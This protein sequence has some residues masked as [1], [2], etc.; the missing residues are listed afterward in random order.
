M[1]PSSDNNGKSISPNVINIDI[2]PNGTPNASTV[3]K[4]KL[5]DLAESIITKDYGPTPFQSLRPSFSQQYQEPISSSEQWKQNKR[6]QQKEDILSKISM[7]SETVAISDDRQVI[8]IT[9]SPSPRQRNVF[10]E[11]VSPT[12][13]QIF[14]H[15]KR[16]LPAPV[17]QEFTLDCYVK[18]RIAEA[19]RTEGDKRSDEGELKGSHHSEHNIKTNLQEQSMMNVM[20]QTITIGGKDEPTSSANASITPFYPY[21]ALNMVASGAQILSPNVLSES[22]LESDN[23]ANVQSKSTISQISLQGS[24]LAEPK[25]LLSAQYEA[26]SDED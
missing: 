16:N 12:D 25:P 17:S 23:A 21:S 14:F 22:N 10:H 4:I 8:K 26:L 20:N 3:A 15:D 24:H 5:G 11:P 2:D 6:M 7:S 13:S 19:M 9:Q 18:S 1:A